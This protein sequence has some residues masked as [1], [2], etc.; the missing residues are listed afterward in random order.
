MKAS[1]GSSLSQI[2]DKWR[3]TGKSVGTSFILWTAISISLRRIDSSISFTKSP[4][5]PTCARGT[6]RIMSPVVFILMSLTS[7]PGSII[8]ISAFTHSACQRASLLPRVPIFILFILFIFF[9]FTINPVE[10]FNDCYQ[11]VFILRVF[12]EGFCRWMDELINN[13][14]GHIFDSI[15][16]FV[17]HL[18]EPVHELLKLF[19]LDLLSFLPQSNNG[20]DRIKRREPFEKRFDLLFYNHFRLL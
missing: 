11:E 3:P 14:G 8:W 16:L 1:L 17:L 2:A 20:W 10:F 5:P 19:F 12:F 4:L 18:R 7:I 13:C 6:A 9:L 15:L